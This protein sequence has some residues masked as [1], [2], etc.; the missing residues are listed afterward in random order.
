[1][2]KQLVDEGEEQEVIEVGCV[3]PLHRKTVAVGTLKSILNQAGVSVEEFIAFLGLMRYTRRGT[4]LPCPYNPPYNFVPH[5]SGN[6]Y[7]ENL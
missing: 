3:V 6:R 4:A 1:M 2:K 5:L 7:I